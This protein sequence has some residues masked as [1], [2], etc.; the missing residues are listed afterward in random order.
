MTLG[1]TVIG[2]QERSTQQKAE[3]EFLLAAVKL[4]EVVEKKG[5]K[6][7][8]KKER[9]KKRTPKA[10]LSSVSCV[11]GCSFTVGGGEISSSFLVEV[12][13]V[14]SFVGF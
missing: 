9:K 14:C 2:T 8:R 6:K 1:F 10:C 7:N 3:L 5:R 4:V 13:S 11:R 12:R